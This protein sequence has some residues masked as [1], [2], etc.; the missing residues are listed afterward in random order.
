MSWFK[1]FDLNP[2][3]LGGQA[4]EGEHIREVWAETRTW[5]FWTQKLGRWYMKS[6]PGIRLSGAILCLQ[7]ELQRWI[8][9]TGHL[10]PGQESLAW[11]CIA[12]NEISPPG[13]LFFFFFWLCQC[14]HIINSCHLVTLT[15]VEKEAIA[16]HCSNEISEIL[17][18]PPLFFPSKSFPDSDEKEIEPRVRDCLS[19]P[20]THF[21]HSWLLK[22]VKGYRPA[23]AIVNMKQAHGYLF[24]LIN[25]EI[26]E[27]RLSA[28][29]ISA[30]NNI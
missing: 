10:V 24:S 27:N 6:G 1:Y 25:C 21:L 30:L 12:P 20:L 3:T 26:Q 4:F 16:A 2:V 9:L 18:A 11:A 13:F 15:T 19:F 8:S 28:P 5:D 22:V 17:P 7:P 14:F 29:I 23:I